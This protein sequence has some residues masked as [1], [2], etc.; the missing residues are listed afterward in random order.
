MI[1]WNVTNTMPVLTHH[2]KALHR[3]HSEHSLI[4][5]VLRSRSPTVQQSVPS[6]F[7]V[8]L[9]ALRDALKCFIGFF[10]HC[11][12]I[13]N[14]NPCLFIVR[15]SF[16]FRTMECQCS[17][18]PQTYISLLQLRRGSWLSVVV[19]GDKRKHRAS[20]ILGLLILNSTL[21]NNY[22]HS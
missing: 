10:T 21:M 19:R 16:L 12:N 17:S 22:Y 18:A 14:A 15:S 1:S 6:A 7:S 2:C 8:Y 9:Y 4:W 11:S 20:N 5:S 3:L 13:F